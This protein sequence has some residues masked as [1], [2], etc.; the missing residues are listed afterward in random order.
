MRAISHLVVPA[1][2]LAVITAK[3]SDNWILECAVAGGA[4]LIVTG[5]R[6]HLLPLGNYRGIAIVTPADFLRSD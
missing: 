3:E 1:F 4:D 6:K 2:T 5:D